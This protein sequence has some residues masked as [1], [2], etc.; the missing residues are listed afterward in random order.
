MYSCHGFKPWHEW[1]INTKIMSERTAAIIGAT[2]MIGNYLLQLLLK[3]SYFST[4]RILVRR[5]YPKT[6]PKIEVKL[7]DFNDAESL[8]LALEGT[9]T[10]FSCVGTTQKNVD[11]DNALYRKIDFDIPLKAA[12]FGKETGCEKFVLVSSVGAE[13]HSRSFYLQL[14]GELENAIHSLGLESVHI[15]QPSVL[16]GDRKE[17]RTGERILQTTMKVMSGLFIGSL[18]KYKAI[19]GKTVAAAMLNAIKKSEKGF[20]R[21]TYDDIQ[22]LAGKF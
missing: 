12:R 14:K 21:Y 19:H 2:G 16:L 7:V 13:K 17:N 8:K 9:D 5:P 6:D 22:K 11:S 20:F 3:D 15:M 1:Q 10:I 18:R 4:V